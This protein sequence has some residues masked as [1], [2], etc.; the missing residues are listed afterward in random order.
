MEQSAVATAHAVPKVEQW[1]Q[2]IMG[3]TPGVPREDK[4]ANRSRGWRWGREA[5][6]S[7][8]NEESSPLLTLSW[9]TEK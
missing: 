9:S 5:C 3:E 2:G 1:V 8:K 7:Y 6:R 4:V